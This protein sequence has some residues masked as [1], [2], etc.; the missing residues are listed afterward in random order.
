VF[1]REFAASLLSAAILLS[2]PSGAGAETADPSTLETLKHQLDTSV[3]RKKKLE[4]Q[5]NATR[6]EIDE[7]RSRL[8]VTAASVQAREAEVS[9]SE[10][11]L[12]AL[13]DAETG[14]SQNSIGG[15]AKWPT[16]WR[17]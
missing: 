11:R 13:K 8:I 14:S 17:R 6:Q 7:I 5:T 4:A 15:A 12:N 10:D 1:R 3:E 9:A 2:I 16:C